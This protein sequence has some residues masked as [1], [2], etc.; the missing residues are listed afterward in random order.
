[1]HEAIGSTDE[2]SQNERIPAKALR[3][4]LA[5]RTPI[6]SAAP[7]GACAFVLNRADGTVT[8]VRT[9]TK[10]VL[11]PIPVGDEPWGAVATPDGRWVYVSNAAADAVSVLDVARRA[12]VATIDVG[13]SPQGLAA[14]PSGHRVYVAN[15]DDDSISAIDTATHSVIGEPIAAGQTPWTLA[16]APDGRTAYV[17][18]ASANAVT[19]IDL[20]THDRIATIAVG[21]LPLAIAITPDGRTAFVANAHSNT[22]TPIDIASHA[23][24]LTV[25]AGPA[26]GAGP[27]IV[28]GEFPCGAAVT[29]DGRVLCV[30]NSGSNTVT[31]IDTASLMVVTHIDLDDTPAGIAIAP[32]GRYA[33]IT[34]AGS[35]VMAAIDL[36]AKV[37][38]NP[39]VP[40]GASPFGPAIGPPIVMPDAQQSSAAFIICD[41][42]DLTAYGFGRFVPFDG[43]ALRLVGSWQT[44]RH[45]SVLTHGAWIDTNGF[46]AIVE[47]DVVNDGSLTKT[48][49]GSLTLCGGIEHRKD[50]FVLEGTLLVES[51]HDAPIFV[52]GGVLGGAGH[53]V[54]VSVTNGAISPGGRRPGVLT[55]DE[56]TLSPRASLIIDINGPVCGTDYD[57]LDVRIAATI[58]EATLVARFGGVLATGTELTIVTNAQGTFAGLPEGAELTT[59]DG[60]HA[61]ITYVGGSGR[62]VVLTVV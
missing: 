52:D 31:L 10:R 13:R 11:P 46:D 42:T 1:M 16:I 3:D 36:S 57:R 48:G 62:D 12:I 30:V 20:V 60:Q 2:E 34:L 49:E 39:A 22:V 45:L 21:A 37:V 55:A 6:S 47:G 18:N 14:T 28:V 9:H 25:A 33:Y 38:I 4:M 61:R 53:V 32:D 50:T 24:G 7:A 29:P 40:V 58:N 43:G 51:R 35:H 17:A 59:A 56:V 23:S 5:P 15:T 19:A 27:A 44:N 8:M 41:D 26:I 54:T